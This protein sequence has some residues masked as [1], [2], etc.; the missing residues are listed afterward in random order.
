MMPAEQ[1]RTILLELLFLLDRAARLYRSSIIDGP[2]EIEP[3]GWGQLC[4]LTE[5]TATQTRLVLERSRKP[6][7]MDF[8]LLPPES[9]TA[10]TLAAKIRARRALRMTR[11]S[12]SGMDLH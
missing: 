9:F 10:P 2:T 4:D 5:R 11:P 3:Y 6:E 8:T 1:S 12:R 7:T